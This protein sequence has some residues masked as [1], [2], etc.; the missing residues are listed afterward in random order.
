MTKLEKRLLSFTTTLARSLRKKFKLSKPI[1]S[2]GILHSNDKLI[3]DAYGW[4]DDK[5]NIRIAF[6]DR[7]TNNYFRLERIV[8][9]LAHEIAHL[10]YLDHGKS[11]DK[12]AKL[13]YNYLK[14]EYL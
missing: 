13:Y 9:T 11:F 2:L 8:K 12:L 3:D 14:K 7:K 4:C 6:K 5:G 1:K 10:T